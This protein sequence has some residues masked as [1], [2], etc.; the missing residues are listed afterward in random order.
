MKKAKSLVLVSFAFPILLAPLQAQEYTDA[1]LQRFC[2]LD[3]GRAC[4]VLA[5]RYS[6]YWWFADRDSQDYLE[7]QM[8]MLFNKAES[9]GFDGDQC[10]KVGRGDF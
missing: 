1:D 7:D 9:L 4:C 8:D 5:Q 6:D 2:V 10:I 3:K